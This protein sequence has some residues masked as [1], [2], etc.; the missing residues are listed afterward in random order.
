ML[1][2]MVVVLGV[3]VGVLFVRLLV[4]RVVLL[5]GLLLGLL[6]LLELLLSWTTAAY[7]MTGLLGA[8]AEVPVEA[9]LQAPPDFLLFGLLAGAL[10][11]TGFGPLDLAIF[12]ACLS[13]GTAG[14]LFFE[15]T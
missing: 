4:V 3:G 7:E 1:L 11:S 13:V 8:D 9:D 15:S 6:L 5:P 2:L 14:V 12:L 10:G